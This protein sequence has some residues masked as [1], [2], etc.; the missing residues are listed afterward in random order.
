MYAIEACLLDHLVHIFNAETVLALDDATV[1]KIASESPE[2]VLERRNLRT[3][4][5]VLDETMVTLR[6]LRPYNQST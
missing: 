4:L 1:T 5:V 2:V 6:Q 3:K